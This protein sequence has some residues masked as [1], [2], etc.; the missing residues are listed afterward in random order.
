MQRKGWLVALILLAMLPVGISSALFKT[1]A[2]EMAASNGLSGDELSYLNIAFSAAQLVALL[3]APF[4][5]SPLH[6]HSHLACQL[7]NGQSV[8]AGF[9][10]CPPIALAAWRNL[11]PLG[12][13]RQ[14]HHADD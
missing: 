2:A 6:G 7:A 5:C 9:R 4:Y 8:P 1:L 3:A 10:L 12:L 11:G 13:L 14:Y